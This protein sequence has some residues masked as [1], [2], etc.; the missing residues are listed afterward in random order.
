VWFLIAWKFASLSFGSLRFLSANI[1]QG[2]VAANRGVVGY[3]FITF[4][5]IYWEVYWWAKLA[6]N[7]V[8]SFFP[9]VMYNTGHITAEK[10]VRSSENAPCEIC[11]AFL[12]Q[13]VKLLH[14]PVLVIFSTAEVGR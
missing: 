14:H 12:M 1:S 5:E 8:A 6:K 2:S 9:D 13:M 4:P 10:L 7:R 11:A 3:L